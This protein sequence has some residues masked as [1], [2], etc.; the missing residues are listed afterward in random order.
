M[1]KMALSLIAGAAALPAL[2]DYSLQ[3]VDTVNVGDGGGEIVSVS[4]GLV[5][6]TADGG[7]N[8]YSF[9]GGSFGAPTEVRFSDVTFSS[10]L[11]NVSSTALDPLNRGFGIATLIPTQ[12]GGEIGKVGLYNTSTG[13]VLGYWDVGYHPDSV[14]FSDDGN[15]AFIANEGENNAVGGEVGGSLTVINLGGV[16]GTGTLGNATVNT[17]GFGGQDLSRLRNYAAAGAPPSNNVEPEYIT[18]SNGRAFVTLQ[19]NNAVGVFNTATSS[20]NRSRRLA[21]ATSRLT[22]PTAT[23]CPP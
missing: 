11:G 21:T 16:T 22:D 12:N 19:E 10:G 14:K 6:A 4:G 15:W 20:W 1:K 23:T 9:G 3:L 7:V 5:A 18:Y 2:G 8:L 17:Y 13:A